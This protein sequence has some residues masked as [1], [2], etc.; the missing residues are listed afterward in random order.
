MLDQCIITDR[1]KHVPVSLKC[2]VARQTELQDKARAHSVERT[3]VKKVRVDE[4]AEPLCANG[5]LRLAHGDE[6][7]F[8]AHFIDLNDELHRVII[9][10]HCRRQE[11]QSQ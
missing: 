10:D 11:R 7:L 9:C 5:S 4:L 1:A 6:H 2:H 3:A 8:P